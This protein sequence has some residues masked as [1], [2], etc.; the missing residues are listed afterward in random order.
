MLITRELALP[1]VE[2]LE[3]ILG[4]PVNI[5]NSE[6]MIV[7]STDESRVGDRHQGAIEAI[8]AGKDLIVT[9]DQSKNLTGTREG[10]TLPLE[11]HGE[12]VGAVGLTGDPEKLALTASVIRVAVL[13]LMEVAHM[14][15]Q[16]SYKDK[17]SDA[18]VSNLI[19]DQFTDYEQLGKQAKF[20]EIDVTKTC[21]AI[22]IH[23][24]P[25]VYGQLSVHEQAIL[26]AASSRAKVH[27]FSYVGQ[28]QYI[29]ATRCKLD[30]KAVLKSVCDAIMGSLGATRIQCRIG[31]GKPAG[32]ISGYRQSYFDALMGAR[33]AERTGDDRHVVYFYEHNILRLLASV[34]E[35]ARK[36]FI[37]N[38]MGGREWDPLLLL[39][40]QTYFAMEKHVSETAAA[41]YI[42]RNTLL[43]RLNKIRELYGLDPRRFSDSLTLQALLYMTA[44]ET[45]D[46]KELV[47]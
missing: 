31:V 10:I 29:L 46:R 12:Y 14:A 20:L 5:I 26:N 8:S 9:R 13:S 22:V 45:A 41:L 17:I 6:G 34:P 2:R 15:Q 39:T 47:K 25:V 30:E 11:L 3:K 40:L 44:L 18:W 38:H 24:S 27:F 23:I 7:A 16:S 32:G 28:G 37:S 43:F 33:F 42:H 19:S 1:I 21:A 4:N 35:L 36:I